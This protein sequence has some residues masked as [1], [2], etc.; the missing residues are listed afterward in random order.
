MSQAIFGK[1]LGMTQRFGPNDECVP[2]TV[3]QCEPCTVVRVKSKDGKDGYDAVQVALKPSKPKHVR[4]PITGE[5]VKRGLPLHRTLKEFRIPAADAAKYTPGQPI[6]VDAFRA[7]Y[8]VD[9]VGI[10]KGRGFAGVVKRHGFHGHDAGHG[11]HEYY[12]HPGT[13]GVGSI[14]PGR[15]PLGMGRPGHYGTDRVTTQ[16]LMIVEVDSEKGLIFVRGAVAGPTGGTVFLTE[17]KKMH[18][19]IVDVRLEAARKEAA[20]LADKK[21]NPLKAAKRAAGK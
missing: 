8:Y 11:A 20:K 13:G 21:L 19:K 6:S 12:R 10:S 2:V 4:K 15:V 7:G 3:I 17:A 18:D 14:F 9:A 16:N 5:L 1:K